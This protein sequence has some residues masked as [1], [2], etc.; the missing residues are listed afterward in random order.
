[1]KRIAIFFISITA[2]FSQTITTI[3]GGGAIW[4]W[5]YEKTGSLYGPW[6]NH[7]LVDTA[8]FIV[9]YDLL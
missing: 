2:L 4:A 8:I 1:M 9:G 3:A 7:A 6:V 5:M